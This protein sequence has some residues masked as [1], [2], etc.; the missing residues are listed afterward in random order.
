MKLKRQKK[1]VLDQ[2]NTWNKYAGRD[3]VLYIHA[4]IGGNN[5]NFYGGF[6]L[7]RQPWFIEKVDDSFDNTYCD[8]YAKISVR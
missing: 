1:K 7:A 5:W 3:N 6:E 8:I 4:R 2:F